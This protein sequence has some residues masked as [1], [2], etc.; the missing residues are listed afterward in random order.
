MNWNVHYMQHWFRMM[1]CELKHRLVFT[2][3]RRSSCRLNIAIG[4]ICH[5]VLG[6][7]GYLWIYALR[8]PESGLSATRE[9]RMDMSRTAASE[10]TAAFVT[11]DS[12]LSQVTQSR[13]KSQ[14]CVL[15]QSV[16]ANN[17][18]LLRLDSTLTSSS[19]Y[20]SVTQT[21]RV[22]VKLCHCTKRMDSNQ[23]GFKLHSDSTR[24]QWQRE[25]QKK[26]TFRCPDVFE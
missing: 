25:L 10:R 1:E 18:S 5:L 26:S 22:Q 2:A 13:V 6:R 16:A 11:C 8:S 3:R 17:K 7:F 21:C 23:P 15:C 4:M 14:V 19:R 24:S 12:S 9:F 20:V